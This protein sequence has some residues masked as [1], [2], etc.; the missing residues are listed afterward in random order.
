MDRRGRQVRGGGTA[1]KENAVSKHAFASRS[2]INAHSSRFETRAHWIVAQTLLYL[3][4]LYIQCLLGT[5][6]LFLFSFLF[7]VPFFL[8]RSFIFFPSFSLSL[9]LSISLHRILRDQSVSCSR[10]HSHD[11]TVR[12]HRGRMRKESRMDSETWSRCNCMLIEC[13]SEYGIRMETIQFDIPFCL[14]PSFPSFVRHPPLS[15]HLVVSSASLPPL[16]VLFVPRRCRRRR[17]GYNKR[18][19]LLRRH[20]MRFENESAPFLSLSVFRCSSVYLLFLVRYFSFSLSCS[21]SLALRSEPRLRISAHDVRRCRNRLPR[22]SCAYM[23]S[24]TRLC[25]REHVAELMRHTARRVTL[26]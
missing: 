15:H 23:I 17:C 12:V 5:R 6:T 11:H 24:Y 18:T 13:A 16:V 21:F 19:P 7:P 9:F 10:T 26:Q 1:A 14:R 4:R 8:S 25:V 3:C 22:I 20:C 2:K